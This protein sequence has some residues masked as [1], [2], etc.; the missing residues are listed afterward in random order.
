MPWKHDTYSSML[1]LFLCCYHLMK[2]CRLQDWWMCTISQLFVYYNVNH[3][4]AI[5]SIFLSSWGCILTWLLL[6][7]ANMRNIPYWFFLNFGLCTLITG[8]SA[9]A[10]PEKMW[11]DVMTYLMIRQI[12]KA[13]ILFHCSEAIILTNFSLDISPY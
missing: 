3:N 1:S 6:N 12:P 10:K 8:C 13:Q 2:K 5:L 9:S 11:C 4:S 7:T